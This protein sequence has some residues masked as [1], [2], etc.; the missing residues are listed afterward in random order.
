MSIKY[1]DADGYRLLSIQINN[2]TVNTYVDFNKTNSWNYNDTKDWHFNG[3]LNA[4]ENTIL[5]FFSGNNEDNAHLSYQRMG[6]QL[7]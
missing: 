4:G 6:D 7:I 1:A 5:F 2:G 3:T